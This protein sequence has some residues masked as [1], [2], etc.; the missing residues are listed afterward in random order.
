MSDPSGPSETHER[1]LIVR[2]S[3]LGDIVQT[4]PVACALRDRFPGARIDW[5]VQ[6]GGASLLEGHSALDNVLAVPRRWM[7]SLGE[8]RRI[9][10]TLRENQY[11]L[12]ID[13]QGLM[14]SAALVS[15]SGASRR[16]GFAR[17]WG[18]ELSPMLMTETV[19]TH[20]FAHIVD[21]N[22]RLMRPFDA[23]TPGVDTPGVDATDINAHSVR[24][25]IPHFPE[26]KATL[27]TQFTE[28]GLPSGETQFA[29]LNVGAGWASKRWPPERFAR[30]AQHL[31]RRHRLIS[32]AVFGDQEERRLA[33]QIVKSSN[34]T[35]RLA[36]KM[37]LQ[38][39]TELCRAA[40]IFVGGDT[41]PLHIAAAVDT[42][43]VGLYGPFPAER[44]GPRGPRCIMIQKMTMGGPVR[45]RRNASDECM[46]AI[47]LE[48]VAQA[49]DRLLDEMPQ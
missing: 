45:E 35:A 32:L 12:A 29:I 38:G 10:R 20:D 37:S 11:D 40:R 22:L 28:I 26:A 39:L 33:Y 34:G 18:R 2:L 7:R 3:A 17:P 24:F 16:I 47:D 44:H 1:I 5:L 49:C 46:R 4:M 6:T 8:I 23:D 30:L 15:L 27:A 36:P 21:R 43:C 13:A 31:A 19:D 48:C 14:K 42:P 9:R 25:D 41:G